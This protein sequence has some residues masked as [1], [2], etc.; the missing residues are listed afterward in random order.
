M[1]EAHLVG[2]HLDFQMNN[3][4]ANMQRSDIN[5]GV[6]DLTKEQI[7][8]A[9]EVS[10]ER[11]I[12]ALDSTSIDLSALDLSGSL[13]LDSTQTNILKHYNPNLHVDLRQTRI[14]TN[15]IAEDIYFNNLDFHYTPELCEIADADFK[16][17]VV[18]K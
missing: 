9:F 15:L 2:S 6:N 4:N 12:A 5:V 3:I 11:T 13:R 1:A 10:M 14:H 16:L 8:A 17:A 18:A 7:A